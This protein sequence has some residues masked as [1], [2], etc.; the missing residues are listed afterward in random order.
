MSHGETEGCPQ[1]SSYNG[2]CTSGNDLRAVAVL[3]A[4]AVRSYAFVTGKIRNGLSA[5]PVCSNLAVLCCLH[6][7]FDLFT[8]S[9]YRRLR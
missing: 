3:E 2:L 6:F 9:F 5:T 7:P 1:S 8:R 4:E